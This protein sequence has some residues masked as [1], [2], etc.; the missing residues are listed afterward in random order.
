MAGLQQ[1]AS[2][3]PVLVF[4]GMKLRKNAFA[5]KG[6]PTD[7]HAALLA[8]KLVA[9]M[10]PSD[11][12]AIVE[13]MIRTKNGF[14]SRVKQLVGVHWVNKAKAVG[15]RSTITGQPFDE[16]NDIIDELG[17]NAT[18]QN[19]Q[20]WYAI[21]YKDTDAGAA[22]KK[23][24]E[25]ALMKELEVQYHDNTLVNGCVGPLRVDAMSALM[26]KMQA[27]SRSNQGFHVV[28]S[29]PGNE[30]E[31]KGKGRRRNGDYY[32]IHSDKN[33]KML[34]KYLH[35]VSDNGV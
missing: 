29:N 17:S 3:D 27:K 24:A 18:M 22:A 12:T 7:E 15:M 4:D 30:N 20:T 32:I 19:F 34:N 1:Y 13:R 11:L 2:K 33:G 14:T 16:V 6:R 21:C 25:A 10:Q 8:G 9:E 5:K 28:K 26:E 31:I 23:E 35:N